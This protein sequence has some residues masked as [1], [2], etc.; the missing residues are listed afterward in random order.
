MVDG[1]WLP[2]RV[3]FVFF[4]GGVHQSERKAERLLCQTRV[5]VSPWASYHSPSRFYLPDS[6]IPERWMGVDSR[7]KDDD[8]SIVTPFSVGP[9]NCIAIKSDASLAFLPISLMLRGVVSL[10]PKCAPSWLSC[11]GTSIWHFRRRAMV[12]WARRGSISSGIG[13][14]CGCSSSREEMFQRSSVLSGF[15]N[16]LAALLS[17]QCLR[18][19]YGRR[20]SAS[21]H[22]ERGSYETCLRS[23]SSGC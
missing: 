23:S 9:R 14:R 8:R 6:F 3:C 18:I 1:Y 4:R 21:R 5:H 22:V 12:G 16:I 20:C 2:Q 13:I 19:S 17:C 7:F 15:A 10:T 11:F